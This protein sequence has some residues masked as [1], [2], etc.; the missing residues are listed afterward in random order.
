MLFLFFQ[1]ILNSKTLTQYVFSLR[2]KVHK[3]GDLKGMKSHNFHIMMQDILLL[4]MRHL[5]A[6]SCRMVIICLNHVSKK[7]CSK[8]VDPNTIANLEDVAMTI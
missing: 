6:K 3:D 4:C 8:V 1:I 2:K 7:L 5:M